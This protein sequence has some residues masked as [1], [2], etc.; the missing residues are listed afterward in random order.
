MRLIIEKEINRKIPIGLFSILEKKIGNELNLSESAEAS[1][2]FVSNEKIKS[3]NKKTRGINKET[4]VL[5]FPIQEKKLKADPDGK[6]RLGDIII[7]FDFAKTEAKKL[8]LDLNQHL[9]MLVVHGL[10]H[11]LGYDHNTKKEERKMFSQTDK[12]LNLIK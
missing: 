3:L 9:L 10:L 1:L 8:N 6:V 2:F 4:D 5:S 12:L 11:L 7:A